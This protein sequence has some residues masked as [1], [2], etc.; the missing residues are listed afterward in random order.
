MERSKK[1]RKSKL[2]F[3]FIPTRRVIENSKK[4]AKKFIILKNTITNSFQA[5]VGW[6][7]MRKR[8]IKITVPFRSYPTRNRKFKKNSKKIQKI[9]KYYYGFISSQNNGGNAKKE[10]IKNIVRFRSN[11]KS[12]KNYHCGFISIQN[13]L[14]KAEKD[15][16]QK[17]SF[18]FVPTRRVIENS[19]KI[20]KKF[21][22]L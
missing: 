17:L 21:K 16:K 13:S 10:K 1:E 5:K 14:K 18:H 9:I 20:A 4:I 3:R 22:K 11:L 6:K 8:E 12:N 15:G 2:S 19:K 7:R